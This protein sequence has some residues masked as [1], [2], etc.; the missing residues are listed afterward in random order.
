MAQLSQMGA[1]RACKSHQGRS[2]AAGAYPR[3][4]RWKTGTYSQALHD[5]KTLP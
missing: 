3:H 5:T 4:R 1:Y 2:G